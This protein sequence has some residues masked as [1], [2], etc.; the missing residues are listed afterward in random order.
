[1]RILIVDD[2]GFARERIARLIRMV[3]YEVVQAASGEEAL[4][5]AQQTTFDAAT[6]DL[7][8]PDMNGVELISRLHAAYPSLPLFA[9][10]ADVQ[11]TTQQEVMQAGASGFIFKSGRLVELIDALAAL[12]GFRSQALVLTLQQHDAFAE[13]IN[14]AMGQAAQALARLTDRRVVLT[15]PKIEIMPATALRS[16]LEDR[17]PLVGACVRQSF[18]GQL[19]GDASLL[20]PPEHAEALTRVVLAQSGLPGLSEMARA[21]L[22]EIGNIVL[23]ATISQLGDQVDARL[24]IGLPVVS[25]SLPLNAAVDILRP[26][27]ANWDHAIVLLNRLTIAEVNLLAFLVILMSEDEIQR[28]LTSLG[29]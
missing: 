7:L 11:R 6:I 28:L 17:L 20:F 2:S 23:N 10:T 4:R 15:V 25:V 27:P 24:H 29:V 9:V 1:M 12:P 8:M 13:T 14:I 18:S 16:F 26:A 21:V 5:L 19:S 3:G 22:G